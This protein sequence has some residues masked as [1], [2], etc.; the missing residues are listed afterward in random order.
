MVPRSP[1][2]LARW[3][4]GSL[5]FRLPEARRRAQRFMVDDEHKILYCP[6][7]KNA[8]TFFVRLILDNSPVA[9]EYRSSDLDPHEFRRRNAALRMRNATP[10]T[11][12]DFLRFLILR[13]PID[14]LVSAYLN[15]FVRNINYRQARLA[16]EKYRFRRGMP[17]SDKF[18][19]F[20][21]FVEFLAAESP[22]KFDVHWR[23]QH[24]LVQP[25]V[26]YF[27]EIVTM[28][29]IP[30]VV[31]LLSHRF[32]RNLPC[33]PTPNRNEYL[34]YPLADK[35]F[36]APPNELRELTK[37]P[38]PSSLLTDQLKDLAERIYRDDLDFYRRMTRQ[39]S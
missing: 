24:L 37:M 9:E 18:L 7:P 19:S 27:D 15:K 31:E 5:E 1:L 30:E 16:T 38:T 39:S 17:S 21:Q 28:E 20:A 29:S 36:D 32:G 3:I 26:K 10:L 35:L 22:R 33:L 13:E 8:C 34:Q 6:I 4:Q 23:P 2:R 25:F 12:P 11:A 14:R